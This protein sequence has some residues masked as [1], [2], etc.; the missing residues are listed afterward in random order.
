MI[1]K[2]YAVSVNN[3][4]EKKRKVN[5]PKSIKNVASIDLAKDYMNLEK[6]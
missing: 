3:T 4:T 1:T 2:N 5:M 6:K